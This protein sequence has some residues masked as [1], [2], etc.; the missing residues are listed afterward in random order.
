[1]SSE[2]RRAAI[3]RAVLP[4]LA[5]H[6]A[7]ITTRQ[8]AQ[9]AGIAEGTV[10]RVFTDKDELLRVCVAEAFRTD[11]VCARVRQ[12]PAEQDLA[13]RLTETGKLFEEHFAR[14]SELMRTLATT[15]YDV[16]QHGPKRPGRT[17]PP[18]F[19][20]DL[21]E[22]I[23]SV[24]RPDAHRLRMPVEDLARMYL[25]MLISIRFDP[26]PEQDTTATVAQR[27][28]VLLRGALHD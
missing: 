26:A 18:E 3:V 7:T 23:C 2:D 17:G 21:A 15:G 14:F 13:T 6:G 8:I 22:A 4:L 28:D 9:A 20:R 11:D 1:M 25:G 19:M 16:R 5:E 27:T 12:V 10:F 24:L